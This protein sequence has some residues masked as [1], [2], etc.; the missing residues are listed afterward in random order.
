MSNYLNEKEMDKAG[1]IPTSN[2]TN[3]SF[4]DQARYQEVVKDLTSQGLS[5]ILAPGSLFIEY[6]SSRG[7]HEKTACIV[8]KL[9]IES[10]YYARTRFRI[11]NPTYICLVLYHFAQN[12]II[13]NVV[14]STDLK[15]LLKIVNSDIRLGEK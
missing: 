8:L 12:Q 3:F 9:Y 13:T 1:W 5:G 11:E 2:I 14:K 7:P 15:I 6:S 10:L 4:E